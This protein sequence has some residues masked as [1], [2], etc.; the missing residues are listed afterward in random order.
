MLHLANAGSGYAGLF[1]EF[2]LSPAFQPALPQDIKAYLFVY[3][4]KH[5]AILPP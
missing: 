4:L 3:I 2:L 5:I 1:C